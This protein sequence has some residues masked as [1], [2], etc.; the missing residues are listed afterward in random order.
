MPKKLN[1]HD[2]FRIIDCVVSHEEHQLYP[3]HSFENDQLCFDK[4]REDTSFW[5]AKSQLF[6]LIR[7]K[8][9]I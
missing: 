4:S 2:R 9:L 6:A 3:I 7:Y 5:R 8:N 1:H